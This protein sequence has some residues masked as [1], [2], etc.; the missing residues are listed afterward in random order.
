MADNKMLM[1]TTNSPLQRP[2]PTNSIDEA[3]KYKD[4][5]VER[6]AKIK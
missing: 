1:L 6:I 2:L 5:L 4:I 3:V